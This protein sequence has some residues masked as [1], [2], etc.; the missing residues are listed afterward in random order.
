MKIRKILQDLLAH[1]QKREFTILIGARQTGKSTLLKQVAES[2]TASGE[3]VVMLNLERKNLLLEINQ[4]PENILKYVQ[5][6]NH[7][8]RY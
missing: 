4:N 3:T 7:P 1:T 6:N 8:S 5:Q 2:L